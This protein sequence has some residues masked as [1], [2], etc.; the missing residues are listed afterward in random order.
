[1][2][3]SSTHALGVGTQPEAHHN[4]GRG[5]RL[6]EALR[7]RR[8]DKMYVLAIEIGV[9]ESAIS[10]WRKGAPI[11]TDNAVKLCQTLDISADWLLLARGNIDQHIDFSISSD[12]RELLGK[13]RVLP[14]DFVIHFERAIESLSS[15]SAPN[16]TDSRRHQI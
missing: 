2:R 10:R 15:S 6:E 5:R 3:D 13:L 12:E 8:I 11:T 1:M 4:L 9:N 16:Q 7:I 14:R